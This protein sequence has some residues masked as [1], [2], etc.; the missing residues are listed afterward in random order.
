MFRSFLTATVALS[1]ALAISAP[2]SAAGLAVFGDGE[3]NVITLRYVDSDIHTVRGA[4][5][6]ALRIRLAA[7][8]VCGAVDPVVRWGDQFY[9]CRE[10]A[11]NRAMAPVNAPL[12][13]EALHLSTRLSAQAGR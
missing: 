8:A 6:L 7:E 5:A 10:A 13:A 11:I 12:V 1:A 9:R 3:P 2:V 4:K